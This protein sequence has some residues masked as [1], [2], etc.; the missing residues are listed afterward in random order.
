MKCDSVLRDAYL[1]AVVES[2]KD[3]WEFPSEE[4]SR[5]V[6]SSLDDFRKVAWREAHKEK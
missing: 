6:K 1:A 2:L 4:N 3:Y 5:C